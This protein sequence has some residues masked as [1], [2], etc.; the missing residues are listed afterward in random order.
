[1][2]PGRRPA[3]PR[4]FGPILI[5]L[6]LL[7]LLAT[8]TRARAQDL[9]LPSR[10][11]TLFGIVATP[12]STEI[13]EKLKS[14]APQLRKLKPGYGFKLL[15]VESRRLETGGSIEVEFSNGYRAGA[16]MIEP[17]DADGKVLLRFAL[18]RNRMPL[19]ATIVATPPNQLFFIDQE[20]PNQAILLIGIGAR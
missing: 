18:E 17:F 6:T 19:G 11:V 9:G 20:L 10:Q 2:S 7:G 5:A 13:D 12:G 1:M 8:D 15:A 14:I 3:L 16:A 4:P